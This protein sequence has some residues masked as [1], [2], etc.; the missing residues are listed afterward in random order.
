[1]TAGAR[2]LDEG[3]SEIDTRDVLLALTRDETTSSLLAD[4]GVDERAIREAIERHPP[5]RP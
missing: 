4:L 5:T 1:M 2:A 3:H